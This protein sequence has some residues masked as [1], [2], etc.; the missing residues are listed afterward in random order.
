MA[1]VGINPARRQQ[2]LQREKLS[3]VDK[4]MARLLTAL[5]IANQ[6]FGIAVNFDQLAANE[7]KREA[8]MARQKLTEAQT[9]ALPSAEEAQRGRQLGF[10]QQQAKTTQIQRQTEILPSAQEAQKMRDTQR[11]QIEQTMQQQQGK[12]VA[13]FQKEFRKDKRASKFLEQ[14]D[15]ADTIGTLLR[16]DNPSPLEVNTAMVRAIRAAGEVGPITESD[17]ARF[18]GDP[19]ITAVAKRAYDKYINGEVPEFDVQAF[20]LL[21]D[22]LKTKAAEGY[23]SQ[24]QAFA[25]TEGSRFGS[26]DQVVNQILQPDAFLNVGQAPQGQQQQQQNIP[27][28]PQQQN[29]DLDQF[30]NLFQSINRQRR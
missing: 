7:V 10:E 5:Q 26:P 22:V 3:G 13:D 30:R 24:A 18:S 11:M 14:H 19:S 9:A 21:G 28:T 4:D 25:K 15:A 8:D 27:D 20:R 12:Q 17:L 16:S 23:R 2:D 29:R 1:I 6:G